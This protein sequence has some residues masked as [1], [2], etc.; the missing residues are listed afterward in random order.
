MHQHSLSTGSVFHQCRLFPRHGVNPRRQSRPTISRIRCTLNSSLIEVFTAVSEGRLSPIDA[1]QTVQESYRN[2]SQIPIS[3]LPTVING[4]GRRYDLLTREMK[5]L[6]EQQDSILVTGIEPVD[7]A[8]MRKL[9]PGVQYHA[10]A[11]TLKW[12]GESTGE[13]TGQPKRL[14][15][16]IGIVQDHSSSSTE[17]EVLRLVSE[18]YGCYT[19]NTMPLSV[20]SMVPILMEMK[21]LEQATVIVVVYNEE[22]ALPE[23]IAGFTDVPV[24]SVYVGEKPMPQLPSGSLS[25]GRTGTVEA[26]RAAA[27]ILK[28]AERIAALQQR[29]NE[30]LAG[31]IEDTL[32]YLDNQEINLESD[33]ADKDDSLDQ[34]LNNVVVND[35]RDSDV[36]S[37]VSSN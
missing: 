31:H 18:F 35:Y 4:N 34:A 1:A 20:T 30:D 9:I 36:V 7:Y 14:P 16:C 11:K 8:H 23:V 37:E 6:C 32:E 15:G 12:S 19:F 22:L 5:E 13:S 21:K 29:P 3:S 25:V 17:V 26:A 33:E 10:G 28:S 24:L 27:K 2:L